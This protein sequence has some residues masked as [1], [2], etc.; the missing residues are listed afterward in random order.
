MITI[1]ALAC[2]LPHDYGIPLS[3]FSMTELKRAAIDRGIVASIGE[4]TIWRWLSQD[5]IKPWNHRSWIFP[6]DPNFAAKAGRILD[7]YE[8]CWE[9]RPL[10]EDEWVISADEKTSIQ[11]RR[12][13]HPIKPPAPARV[14]RVEAEYRRMGALAYIA[15]WDVKQA[16]V[17]GRCEAKTGIEPF[18]RLVL[19]VMSREPYRSASRVFWIVD[20]GS[21]HRG[22]ASIDRLQSRWNNLVLV[23]TPVHAS[24]LNQVEIYFSV[25]QRKVLTPNDFASVQE[26]RDRILR[27][28]DHYEQIARPFQWKF[29]RNDLQRLMKRLEQ[30][31]SINRLA[32]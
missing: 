13:R 28:Q 10:A 30:H 4:T 2:E 3:R 17:F 26:L 29:T 9:G 16:R 15:A 32:A 19:Q 6:R 11:A 24:W 14:M 21:S 18:D 25:L 5:A 12:R 31:P 23:H 1:K 22:Q 27:F 8:G 7:L 20:N